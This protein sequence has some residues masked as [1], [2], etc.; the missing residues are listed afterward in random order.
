MLVLFSEF[1]GTATA[2][3]R[4]T[5][6]IVNNEKNSVMEIE[7]STDVWRYRQAYERWEISAKIAHWTARIPWL[8]AEEEKHIESHKSSHLF[9]LC[10][11]STIS[12][13]KHV[14][15]M[16]LICFLYTASSISTSFSNQ[17]MYV[18]VC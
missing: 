13:L 17:R 6:A 10:T 11:I 16:C 2:T 15:A 5:T 12:T 4:T 14:R 8:K 18:C 9:R 3:A 1:I 7:Y